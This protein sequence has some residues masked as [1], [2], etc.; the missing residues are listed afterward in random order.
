MPRRPGA[1]LF[2]RC[3]A[4]AMSSTE[5]PH[6]FEERKHLTEARAKLVSLVGVEKSEEIYQQALAQASKDGQVDEEL[7]LDVI[8]RAYDSHA[9]RESLP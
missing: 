2:S 8:E 1:S 6:K 5:S 9:R 3:Y 4:Y 7:L